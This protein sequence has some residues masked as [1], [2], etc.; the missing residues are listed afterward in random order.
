MAYKIQK[1]NF[2]KAVEVV[3]YIAQNTPIPDV[4]HIGKILYFADKLH[5]E[6]YGRQ[7]NGDTY[8]AFD[9]GPAPS[10]T[11]DLM[12]EHKLVFKR[13]QNAIIPHRETNHDFFSDSDIECLNE[14]IEMYGNMSFEDLKNASH[15][16]AYNNTPLNK[17]IK[18]DDVIKTLSNSEDLLEY[19]E[20]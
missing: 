2:N 12:N 17:P 8:Y 5:L 18:I 20:I 4:Y 15:D 1:M 16:T 10:E 13:E 7:I 19:L 6:K 14:S 11:L 3:L 9:Y